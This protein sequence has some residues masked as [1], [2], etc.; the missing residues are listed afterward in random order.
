MLNIEKT[1]EILNLL[2]LNL[3]ERDN[4][5][6]LMDNNNDE[7]KRLNNN[8]K[9]NDYFFVK[10]NNPYYIQLS[11]NA[12]IIKAANGANITIYDNEFLYEV[13]DENSKFNLEVINLTNNSLNF[14]EKTKLDDDYQS[15]GIRAGFQNN[16]F[17]YLKLSEDMDMNGLFKK[18]TMIRDSK[19]GTQIT[20]MTRKYNDLGKQI[21]G[22]I[23]DN[24]TTSDLDDL[25]TKILNS[26]S[27]ITNLT[28][29]LESVIPGITDI[30][31]NNYEHLNRINKKEKTM[32]K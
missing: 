19:E 15:Y 9:M 27:I 31:R 4:G 22:S 23:Q 16:K 28:D 14:Y 20:K 2:D 3:I 26:Q 10:D 29:N 8:T 7:V 18:D 1:N 21:C 30:L 17:N 5:K 6:F 11:D 12:L 25:I 24:Y 32:I 13:K